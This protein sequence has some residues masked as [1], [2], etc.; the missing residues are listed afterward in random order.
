MTRLESCEVTQEDRLA[1]KSILWVS[2]LIDDEDAIAEAFARHRQNTRATPTPSPDA[3]AADKVSFRAWLVFAIEQARYNRDALDH[4]AAQILT[5]V[6][7]QYDARGEP[8]LR[9]NQEWQPIET[10]PLHKRVL[11]T[12]GE[13]VQEC[14]QKAPGDW[15]SSDAQC[16]LWSSP[17]HWMPR[18]APP[19]TALETGEVRP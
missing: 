7:E 4:R 16:H 2:T 5:N 18:P 3:D 11:A 6:L 14:V 10:A 9:R 13:T 1:A 8:L 19:A 15:E 12:D 17:T